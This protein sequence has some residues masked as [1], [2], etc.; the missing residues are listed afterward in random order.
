MVCSIS[1]N[2]DLLTLAART[3]TLCTL[4]YA[5]T[6]YVSGFLKRLTKPYGH[7]LK[8]PKGF[9]LLRAKYIRSS[10]Q[11]NKNANKLKVT[12]LK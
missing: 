7:A 4:F 5:I 8:L 3:P 1:L 11:D 9:A 12:V 10:Q 6:I 2:V